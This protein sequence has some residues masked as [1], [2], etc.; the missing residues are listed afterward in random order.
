[1]KLEA[2]SPLEAGLKKT[3]SKSTTAPAKV[4]LFSAC[5]GPKQG[6]HDS[7]CHACV[8]CPSQ[9]RPTV[10]RACSGK[11]AP[12]KGSQGHALHLPQ[13]ALRL[14]REVSGVCSPAP[15][16]QKPCSL[17]PAI[18]H[19]R[20]G[21]GPGSDSG[22][23]NSPVTPTHLEYR[24]YVSE[25]DRERAAAAGDCDPVMSQRRKRMRGARGRGSSPLARR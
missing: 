8:P 21:T 23:G 20:Q 5:Q 12:C 17:L 25:R 9:S 4:K 19:Q 2:L 18:H 24:Q 7:A 3:P 13:H 6:F 15:L 22:D 10:L 1:M 11:Q 14:T 16:P